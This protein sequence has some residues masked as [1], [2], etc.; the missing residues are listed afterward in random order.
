M[1]QLEV[2]V[3]EQADMEVAA[4]LVGRVDAFKS[5]RPYYG[6]EGGWYEQRDKVPTL[7][8]IGMKY[9]SEGKL[10]FQ[11]LPTVL[12]TKLDHWQHFQ[13]YKGPKVMKCSRC[14]KFYTKPNRFAAHR[15]V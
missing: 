10:N 1:G 9:V 14:S 13:E 6:G 5:V 12:R 15:C 2:E 3:H 8:S 7:F 11:D 4:V